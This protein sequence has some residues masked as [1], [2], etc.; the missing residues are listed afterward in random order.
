MS[1]L[2]CLIIFL[3]RYDFKQSASRKGQ[4]KLKDAVDLSMCIRLISYEKKQSELS[5]ISDDQVSLVL[6][7]PPNELVSNYS[8][9]S[10]N[11]SLCCI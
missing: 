8:I 11:V 2:R 5:A 7:T 6:E 10:E 9:G 4:R 1:Y 3:K